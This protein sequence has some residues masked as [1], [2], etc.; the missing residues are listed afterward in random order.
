MMADRSPVG[1]AGAARLPLMT[2]GVDEGPVRVTFRAGKVAGEWPERHARGEVPGVWP[3]GL[4]GLESRLAATLTYTG[5]PTRMQRARGRLLPPLLPRTEHAVTWD[6]ITAY[7]VSLTRRPARL[8]SGVIWLTDQLAR[9]EQLD[10]MRRVLR[11]ADAL[12]VLSQAQIEPLE[13]ALGSGSPPVSFVRFGVDPV[14]FSAHGWPDRPRILSIGGDR[15]RDT[16]TLYAALDRVHRARGEVDLVVQTS[17]TLTPPSGVSTF[18]HVPHLAL[19]D[20]YRTATTV[21]IATRP[22]LHVSG[23]TVSLEAM[24]TGRPVVITDSPG[25]ADYVPDQIAAH[26]TPPGDPD[27]LADALIALVDDPDR[28]RAMGRAAAAHVR[29]NHTATAMSERIAEVVRSG[30]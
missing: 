14:F 28:A 29:R 13:K 1:V 3:Y 19:R 21:A 6:E 15:D 5:R 27:A 20:L 17:S 23:M 11:R 22:N 2:R 16:A 30:R 7:D 24:A 9:G 4:E 26:V 8:T 18:A 25:M 12:W 10:G